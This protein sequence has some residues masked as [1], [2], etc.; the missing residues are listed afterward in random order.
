M[1]IVY[2]VPGVVWNTAFI[3]GCSVVRTFSGAVE[4]LPGLMLI[5]FETDMDPIF[6]PP[7][8]ANALIDEEFDLMPVKI[9]IYYLD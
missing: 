2:A 5:P 7:E 8:R 4:L 1:R 6:A 3:M 9:G